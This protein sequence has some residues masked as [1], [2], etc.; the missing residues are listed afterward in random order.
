MIP[1]QGTGLRL[2]PLD[3]AIAADD[4]GCDAAVLQAVIAVETSGRGFDD[5]DRPSMLFEPAVFYRQL[6]DKG[7]TETLATAVRYRLAAPAWGEIPYAPDSY[8]PLASAC[9]LD[10]DA[11]LQSASW[12]LGQ[13]MGFNH[14]LA[15]FRDAESMVAAAMDSE[16]RQLD[17][18]VAFLKAEHLVPFLVARDWVN[19]ALRY[20]GRAEAQHDYGGRLRDAYE[21]AQRRGSAA[22]SAPAETADELNAAELGKLRGTA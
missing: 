14:A 22:P 12:G 1:F 3:V 20:N 9:A 10:R 15:G 16:R 17:M 11:A 21:A 6:F 13:I 5:H 19:F 7:A 4:L 8:V 2:G 18:M